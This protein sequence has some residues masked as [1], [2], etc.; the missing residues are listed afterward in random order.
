MLGSTKLLRA[1]RDIIIPTYPSTLKRVS[2]ALQS[3]VQVRSFLLVIGMLKP[4]VAEKVAIRVVRARTITR[5]PL[6]TKMDCHR[7]TIRFNTKGNLSRKLVATTKKMYRSISTVLVVTK[8]RVNSL[9]KKNNKPLCTSRNSISRHLVVQATPEELG[10]QV[11]AAKNMETEL[12]SDML[13]MVI[14]ETTII[15]PSLRNE[16]S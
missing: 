15:E 5:M 7:V 4:K 12:I 8:S 11:L 13:R 2:I 3:M 16:F 1:S 9:I 6:A 14:L 10:L